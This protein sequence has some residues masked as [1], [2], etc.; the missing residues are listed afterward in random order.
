M[1]TASDW[2]M[3]RQKEEDH[4]KYDDEVG[5]RYKNLSECGEKRQ[6]ED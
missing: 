2:I 3:I 5:S 6:N 1:I 4:D